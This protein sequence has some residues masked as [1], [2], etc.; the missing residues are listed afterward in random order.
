MEYAPP[1]RLGDLTANLENSRLVFLIL[2]S[3]IPAERGCNQG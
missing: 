3:F 1:A 2:G